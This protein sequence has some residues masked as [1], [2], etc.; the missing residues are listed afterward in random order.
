MA[1]LTRCWSCRGRRARVAHPVT[2]FAAATVLLMLASSP[3]STQREEVLAATRELS[4]GAALVS[5]SA[6]DVLVATCTVPIPADLRADKAFSLAAAAALIEARAEAALFLGGTYAGSRESGTDSSTSSDGTSRR[7]SWVRTHSSSMARVKLAAGEPLE[8]SRV[9][10][11]VRV[12][13]A[14]GLSGAARGKSVVTQDSIGADADAALSEREVPACTLRWLTDGEGKEGLMVMIAIHPSEPLGPCV[15]S[16]AKEAP[17]P[18]DCRLCREKALDVKLQSV[19]GEWSKDGDV[20]VVR[21]LERAA[22][23]TRTRAKDGAETLNRVASRSRS[24]RTE[25]SVQVS[26]PPDFFSRSLR[27]MRHSD[28]RSVCVAFVPIDAVPTPTE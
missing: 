18:C 4:A 17:A 7:D 20:G 23:R 2:L 3:A 16:Q 5:T 28:A 8:I 24:A 13:V 9:A 12:L 22:K 26:I 25:A 11:G 15:R 14:W 1:R 27:A 19:I 6:G 10:E 21:T